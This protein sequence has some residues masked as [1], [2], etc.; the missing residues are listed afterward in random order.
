MLEE[1]KTEAIA[2]LS[3][4]WV[5]AALIFIGMIGM[6][7]SN[8]FTSR[9]LTFWQVVGSLGLAFFVGVTVSMVCY[10]YEWERAGMVLVP[11][12]TLLSEKIVV[13][14]LAINWEKNIKETLKNKLKNW[15]NKL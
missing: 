12:C 6:V 14:V 13:A 10:F 9:K 8:L 7:S 3:K 11:M 1:A 2:L 5:W 15:S 4:I